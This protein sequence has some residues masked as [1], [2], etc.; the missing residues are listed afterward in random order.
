MPATRS[1]L[2]VEDDEVLRDML[3]EQLAD[4]GFKVVTASTLEAADR[5]INDENTYVD[6][7]ILDL[8]MP[9]GDG[10]DFCGKLRH[11]GHNVPIIMLTGMVGEEDVVR[12]LDSGAYDYIPKPFRINELLARLRAQLRDFENSE[13]ATFSIGPYIFS[14]GKKLLKDPATQRRIRLTAKEAAILKVLYRSKPLPIDRQKLLHEVWGYTPDT[15][16]HT[17]ETHIYRLR[18]KMESNP[19]CPLILLSV[20]GGY[21]LSAEPVFAATA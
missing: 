13:D 18:Q 10:R 4:D 3:K 2:I 20:Q 19:A 9:D 21:L 5:A 1:V 8:G 6:A 16:T 15:S 11:Q 17:V 7:V 14:P 12:G